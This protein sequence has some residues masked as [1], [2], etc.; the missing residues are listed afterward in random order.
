MERL[1][2]LRILPVL[3]ILAL[4]IITVCVIISEVKRLKGL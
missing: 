4:F 2:H 1:K 3:V